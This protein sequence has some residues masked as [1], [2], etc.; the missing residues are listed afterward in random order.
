MHYNEN[1]AKGQAS[2]DQDPDMEG[3]VRGGGPF[4]AKAQG[5]ERWPVCQTHQETQY[6]R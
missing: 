5:Q 6:L 4:K 2:T 3:K 1:A